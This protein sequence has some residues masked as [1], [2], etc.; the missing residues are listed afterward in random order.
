LRKRYNRS[1]ADVFRCFNIYQ[2]GVEQ[3]IALPPEITKNM[4]TGVHTSLNLLPMWT[5]NI[6][7]NFTQIT[8]HRD[9]KEIKGLH[10]DTRTPAIV[11]GAGPSLYDN[12]GGADQLRTLAQSGCAEKCT[13]IA[14]DRILKDCYEHGIYPDFVVTVD[15]S[16]K[17]Y[18]FYD[19][20]IIRAGAKH[21]CAVMGNHTHPDIVTLWDTH[22]KEIYFF[23]ASIPNEMLPNASS[24]IGLI[25][26]NSELNSGGNSGSFALNV[27]QHMGCN[28]IGIIGID[29]SYKMNT[30]LNET[31]YYSSYKERTGKSDEE[32]WDDEVFQKFHHPFFNTDCYTDYMYLSYLEPLRDFWISEFQRQGTRIVSCVEGGALYG[33]D[34]ECMYFNDFLKEVFECS[35]Q[36]LTNALQLSYPLR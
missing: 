14:T 17:I 7:N 13:V 27:A 25:T 34:I 15:G 3:V 20:P 28:P 2:P 24:T 16:E 31:Q 21:T 4:A 1:W 11:I 8:T 12:A 29:L 32:M 19:D 10:K 5:K 35:E 18:P 26:D 23:T 36:Q 33:D 6:R 30:P 22:G 9:I